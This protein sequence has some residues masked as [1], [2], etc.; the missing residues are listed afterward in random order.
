[1]VW[2]GFE[3]VTFC[4]ADRRSPNW[5]N[6][7]AIK[8]IAIFWKRIAVSSFIAQPWD[9]K[10]CLIFLFFL[11][12]SNKSYRHWRPPAYLPCSTYEGRKQV[13]MSFINLR[14]FS[15]NFRRVLFY[16]TFFRRPKHLGLGGLGGDRWK[17]FKCSMRLLVFYTIQN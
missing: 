16:P 15:G 10:H 9:C 3:T 14:H 5:A 12:N 8:D 7:A 17:Y 2:P 13:D 1:M 6:Q 11:I 4:S